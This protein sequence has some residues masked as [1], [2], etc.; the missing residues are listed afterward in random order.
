MAEHVHLTPEEARL[1]ARGK[2]L[3]GRLVGVLPK[4]KRGG[5]IA[6]GCAECIDL[7]FT[8]FDALL[9]AAER[10]GGHTQD[11]IDRVEEYWKRGLFCPSNIV[12]SS[13][14]LAGKHH[15]T[16]CRICRTALEVA[17]RAATSPKNAKRTFS[18]IE[19]KRH[20]QEDFAR[21]DFA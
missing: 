1:I 7:L 15:L 21:D 16:H 18:R 5:K 2:E 17:E 13:K 3:E 20:G 6:S 9:R 4:N 8:S 19:G 12:E 14:T 11:F 10:N